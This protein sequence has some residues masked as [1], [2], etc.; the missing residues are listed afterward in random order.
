M[1][2]LWFLMA[3]GN[4]VPTRSIIKVS[5]YALLALIACI[6]LGS[7]AH[8]HADELFLAGRL[9]IEGELSDAAT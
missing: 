9:A 5:L 1:N 6:I 2:M 4:G 8:A 3:L 7:F